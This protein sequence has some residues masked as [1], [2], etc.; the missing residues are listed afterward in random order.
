MK[1]TPLLAWFTLP[2]L[3]FAIL[4]LALLVTRDLWDPDYFW[5]LVTGQYIVEHGEI[6]RADI[7]SF[8]QPGKPWVAH[9]WLFQA[10]LYLIHAGFGDWGVK[11]ITAFL[12]MLA[13]YLAYLAARIVQ[14][15]GWMP[16]ILALG[17]LILLTSFSSP[18]PQLISFVMFAAY[19]LVLIRIKYAGASLRSLLWL[20]PLMAVWVNMHGGYVAGFALVT[21]F[22]M[23]E[24][25][26]AW[27]G[28]WRKDDGVRLRMMALVLLGMLL[29]SAVNP[30][31]VRHWFYPF[32]VMAMEASRSMISEWASP[33]FHDVSGK[34]FLMLV[35]AYFFLCAW[36]TSRPDL[37]ELALPVFFILA[38]LVAVRHQPLALLVLLPFMARAWQDM[39]FQA[40]QQRLGPLVQWWQRRRGCELGAKEGALNGILLLAVVMVL[41]AY[42]PLHQQS[43]QERRDRFAPFSAVDFIESQ[44]L[45]GRIFST[46][47]YGGYLIYRLYPGRKVFIDGRADMYGDDFLKEHGRIYGGQVGWDKDFDKWDIDL[48]LTELDAPIRQLLLARGDFVSVYQDEY[49]GVLA[50]RTMVEEASKNR[51]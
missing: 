14:P 46:Y 3:A 15:S 51:P 23:T 21:L 9:E 42:Y 18:R 41:L 44:H 49:N 17:L 35:F 7:F 36:R 48:V 39:P 10:F 13:L 50:R 32:E 25:I 8:T 29:A 27:Y 34:F 45:Q 33:D 20:P 47:H 2:R 11:F 16:L 6:P 1:L 40:V 30:D 24:A 22:A 26:Q 28:G 5:H 19:L 12:P 43:W 4:F 37:T 31:H 38:S